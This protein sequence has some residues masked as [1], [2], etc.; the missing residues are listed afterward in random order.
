[1]CE[2]LCKDICCSLFID[3]L[4]VKGVVEVQTSTL[5]RHEQYLLLLL[6]HLTFLSF[7]DNLSTAC[8][9]V[10]SNNSHHIDVNP[11]PTHYRVAI[12][13]EWTSCL[14][15]HSFYSLSRSLDLSSTVDLVLGSL[16]YLAS[17]GTYSGRSFQSPRCCGFWNC[18]RAASIAPVAPQLP[19]I[20]SMLVR[21]PSKNR[22]SITPLR[23]VRSRE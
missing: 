17:A 23:A 5:I 9:R 2:R 20:S 18:C 21:S 11:H 15:L 4:R 19:I 22:S 12:L 6:S 1:M 10:E 7:P 14:K 13:K 16:P 3:S 8:A